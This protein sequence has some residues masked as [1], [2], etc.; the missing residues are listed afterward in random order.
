MPLPEA[1]ALFYDCLV[2]K[3]VDYKV[4]KHGTSKD[5]TKKGSPATQV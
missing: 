5:F 3:K 4:D 1:G 2:L